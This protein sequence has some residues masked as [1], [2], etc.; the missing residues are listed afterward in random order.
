MIGHGIIVGSKGNEI[1]KGRNPFGTSWPGP[2]LQGGCETDA[3]F[4]KHVTDTAEMI[5]TPIALLII[6][7]IGFIHDL[8]ASLKLLQLVIFKQS[9]FFVGNFSPQLE[10]CLCL[11]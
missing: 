10:F 8:L 2:H 9:S 11:W 6:L 4:W 1:S 7:S 3:F 5:V